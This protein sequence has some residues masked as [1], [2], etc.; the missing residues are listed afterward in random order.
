MI[1][2]KAITIEPSLLWKTPKRKINPKTLGWIRQD[3]IINFQTSEAAENYV[4]TRC[5]AA[6]SIPNPFER[7]ILTRDN[8]ILAEVDGDFASVDMTQYIG[9]M[10]GANFFHGHTRLR[11]NPELPLSL[12]D[13]LIMVSQKLKKVVAFNKNGEYSIL[14]QKPQKNKI[15]KLLPIKWQE[16]LTT[17]N[18]K[19]MG[20]T[21]TL[22]FA[23]EYVKLFPKEVQRKL[24]A[25]FHAEIGL[26]FASK[27]KIN[28]KQ[29]FSSKECSKID[30]IEEE[31]KENGTKAKMISDFWK[32][33]Q[34]KINCI[35]ETNYTILTKNTNT[36]HIN[37][38]STEHYVSRKIYC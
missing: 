14:I 36:K 30:R 17:Y 8:Q 38:S 33:C 12:S 29:P 10:E 1:K 9:K 25:A 2:T 15:L 37:S 35:Y 24:E 7:G 22:E 19:R 27:S 34:N 11:N 5:I 20:R 31:I 21:A 6:L 28:N 3:G 13:Y 4:K 26:P 16:K 18:Q 23:K 32:K